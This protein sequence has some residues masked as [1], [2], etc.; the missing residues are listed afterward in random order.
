MLGILLNEEGEGSSW[1]EATHVMHVWLASGREAG[2]AFRRAAM[3]NLERLNIRHEVRACSMLV[4]LNARG[5]PPIFAF[6]KAAS[7]MSEAALCFRKT[8][9]ADAAECYVRSATIF[10]ENGRFAMA[11]KQHVCV[12]RPIERHLIES[13][14]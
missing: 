11:A 14:R 12:C 8:N 1:G 5:S 7:Q 4:L 2:E 3:L 6:A 10:A 13:R 9:P